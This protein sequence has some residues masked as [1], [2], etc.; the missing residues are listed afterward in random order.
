MKGVRS[1]GMGTSN[2]SS[3]R[4]SS[5][6]SSSSSSSRSSS[7]NSGSSNSSSSSLKIDLNSSD[8]VLKLEDCLFNAQIEDLTAQLT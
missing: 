6:T 3:S 8:V 4:S 5:R 7:R 1:K 2:S